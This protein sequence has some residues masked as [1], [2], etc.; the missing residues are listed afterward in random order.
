MGSYSPVLWSHV[1]VE[2][3]LPHQLVQ[4]VEFQE[5]STRQA[6]MVVPLHEN[7]YI[8][9]CRSFFLFVK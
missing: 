5:C 9:Y 4:I 3:P 7:G 1:C 6:A 2:L 8:K